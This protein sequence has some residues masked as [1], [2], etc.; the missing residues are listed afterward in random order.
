MTRLIAFAAAT[1]I[2]ATPAAAQEPDAKQIA[3]ER[4]A[5]EKDVPQLAEVLRLKPGMTVADIGSGG[6]AFTVVFGKW[7]GGGKVYAT[8]LT[9]RA[10][11]LTREYAAREGLTNVTVLEGAPGATNLPAACCDAMFMRD[12]YHHVTEVEAFN[13][14]LYASLKPGGRLAILDFRPDPGSKL[15]PGVPANREGHGIKP[16]LIEDELKAAGFTHVTTIERWPPD[17]KNPLF[18]VLFT[19]P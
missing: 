3:Q 19:K 8:D 12:V 9:E 6:G 10:L 16:N 17:D 13:K 14:S 2:A 5:A 11:R 15:F 18:L 4:R 1:L 7:I